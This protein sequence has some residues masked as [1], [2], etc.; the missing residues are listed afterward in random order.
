[1]EHNTELERLAGDKH[2]S[3]WGQFVGYDVSST[4]KKL[5]VGAFSINEPGREPSLEGK[6]YYSCPACTNKFRSTAFDIANVIYFFI[7]HT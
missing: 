5:H 3:F 2:N 7:N 6:D 1:M 4:T